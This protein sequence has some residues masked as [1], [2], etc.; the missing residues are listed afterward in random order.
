[1]HRNDLQQKMHIFQNHFAYI[2][3]YV[4]TYTE[5]HYFPSL[6]TASVLSMSWQGIKHC[7]YRMYPMTSR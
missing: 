4:R 1:M 7:K 6:F 2:T 3:Y 5:L